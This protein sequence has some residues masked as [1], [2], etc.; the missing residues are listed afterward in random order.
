[1][2]SNLVKPAMDNSRFDDIIKGKLESYS[3]NAKPSA[4]E[5]AALQAALPSA[6]GGLTNL[7]K[8]L[9]LISGV[10]ILVSVYFVR[11]TLIQRQS[12]EELQFQLDNIQL[13]DQQVITVIDTTYKDSVDILTGQI[14]I[15]RK[16]LQ[17]RPNRIV[18]QTIPAPV[19]EQNALDSQAIAEHVVKYVI[20]S[21]NQNAQIP[22]NHTTTDHEPT[23]STKPISQQLTE[24]QNLQV[25]KSL[26]QDPSSAP[27]LRNLLIGNP[28]ENPNPVVLTQD[29][30]NQKLEKLPVERQEEIIESY[31]SY[32]PKAV[33]TAMNEN[34][35][36]STLVNQVLDLGE[37]EKAE[38]EAQPAANIVNEEEVREEQKKQRYQTL[39]L[40][41]GGGI[42]RTEL[43]I[44]DDA[45]SIS[46]SA[47]IEKGLSKRLSLAAGVDY[48]KLSGEAY[49][50][51]NDDLMQFSNFDQL[52]TDHKE[53]KVNF[54][55]L[56]IPL[57]ARYFLLPDGSMSPYVLV[58]VNLR[59][60]NS[61]VFK[62]ESASEGE[63]Y[64]RSEENNT[65]SVPNFGLGVGIQQKISPKM[66]ARLQVINNVGNGKLGPYQDPLNGING[67]FLLV[68]KLR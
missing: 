66:W 32:D 35:I 62:L 36:D 37:G 24:E 40:Y 57:Q 13:I 55:W 60:L 23:T 4:A 49:N 38:K 33:A 47:G 63:F 19:I 58:S 64:L 52:P 7:S 12:V 15:L 53:V 27:A 21:L 5:F 30:I 26:G 18:Y 43:R 59:M 8:A 1:M 39:S 9:I 6:S 54:S 10:L 28:P 41:A 3:S 42:N 44:I 29:E 51:S 22:S 25:L 17:E 48:F 14:T 68:Y 20:A 46:L 45:P 56:D 31:L 11:E 16:Q 67:Q 34:R 65:L 2:S 61:A 50:V